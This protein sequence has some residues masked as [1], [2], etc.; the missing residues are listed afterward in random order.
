MFC[1]LDICVCS[2]KKKK[3]KHIHVYFSQKCVSFVLFSVVFFFSSSIYKIIIQMYKKSIMIID[4]CMFVS[5]SRDYYKTHECTRTSI[6]LLSKLGH[7]V[8]HTHVRVSLQ[9][10]CVIIHIIIVAINRF[11]HLQYI[12]WVGGRS[13]E[14]ST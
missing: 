13:I 6:Y 14:L 8:M 11:L 9:H 10:W 2:K 12:L 3:A 7:A 4:M 1:V 5:E